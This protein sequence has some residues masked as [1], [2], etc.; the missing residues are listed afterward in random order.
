MTFRLQTERTLIRP[1]ETSDRE[2]FA[3]LATDSRVMQYITDGRPWTEDEIDEFLARQTRHLAQ[4][5]FCLGALCL[6]EAPGVAGLCG[7]QPLGT[8][9]DVEVGWWLAPEHWGQG[10]ATEAARG[11]L[12]FAR[13]QQQLNRLLAIKDRGMRARVVAERL[14]RYDAHLCL[15]LLQ[16]VVYRSVAREARAREVLL[17]LAGFTV[18]GDN[19]ACPRFLDCLQQFTPVSMIGK[20][21][22]LVVASLT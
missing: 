10:L 22:T 16:A 17:E 11:V 1:W 18:T 4:H 9:S 2:S 19:V 20:C 14:D 3:H 15:A 21:E 7:M 8:T 12:A 13:K 5:G 6:D